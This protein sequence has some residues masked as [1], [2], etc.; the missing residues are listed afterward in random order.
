MEGSL[1][2][3]QVER[4]VQVVIRMGLMVQKQRLRSN[5]P[6]LGNLVPE[7][8]DASENNVQAPRSIG[9]SVFQCQE[10][11][12]APVDRKAFLE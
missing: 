9:E 2:L 6:D 3:P 10:E 1:I 5:A 8:D 4:A 7:L 12:K 11:R